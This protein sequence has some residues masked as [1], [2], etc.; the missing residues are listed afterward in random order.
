VELRGAGIVVYVELMQGLGGLEAEVMNILWST[1]HSLSVHDVVERVTAVE[2][3]APAYTT[4]LTVVT[5]LHRKGWVQ[6][7]KRSRAFFYSPTSSRAEATAHALRA[8]LDDSGNSDA[9]LLHFARTVTDVEFDAFRRGR[10]GDG[11]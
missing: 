4:I 6:R 3:R 5:N 2:G 8:L 9:V 1:D 7:E 11:S 10:K